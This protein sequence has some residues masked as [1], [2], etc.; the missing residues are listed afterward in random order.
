MFYLMLLLSGSCFQLSCLK[1]I[2]H[3]SEI[4]FVKYVSLSYFEFS[5]CSVSWLKEFT[6][7]FYWTIWILPHVE[8]TRTSPIINKS[9]A[10]KHFSVS[11]I[12]YIWQ[13]YLFF[14]YASVWTI[15]EKYTPACY[16]HTIAL[17]CSPQLFLF[18][19]IQNKK[20]L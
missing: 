6:L 20:H 16:F 13:T 17:P 1:R 3:I 2:N 12:V 10:F 8:T 14:K 11:F 19:T 4:W 5:F 18:W 15:N 9:C 7:A